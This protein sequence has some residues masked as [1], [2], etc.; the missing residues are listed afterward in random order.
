MPPTDLAQYAPVIAKSHRDCGN[1]LKAATQRICSFYGS[2]QTETDC[3]A[4]LVITRGRVIGR[5]RKDVA[6]NIAVG[7]DKRSASTIF[8]AAGCLVQPAHVNYFRAIILHTGW[9]KW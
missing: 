8:P 1:L 2:S 6:V 7:C 5:W 3:R 4:P 9:L